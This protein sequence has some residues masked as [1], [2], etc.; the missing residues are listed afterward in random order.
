LSTFSAAEDNIIRFPPLECRLQKTA[1]SRV[2]NNQPAY[3]SPAGSL[4]AIHIGNQR[5][6]Q[7]I[8][9]VSQSQKRRFP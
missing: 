3:T 6:G 1:L 4:I 5:I 8:T 2:V 7:K 9:S